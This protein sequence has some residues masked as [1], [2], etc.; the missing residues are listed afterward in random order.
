MRVGGDVG[1]DADG[2][3][4]PSCEDGSARAQQLQLARAFDIE[5]QDAGLQCRVDFGGQLADAGEHDVPDAPS[6]GGST[7]CSSPPETMSKP[8]PIPAS[9]RRIDKI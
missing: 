3:I 6:C 5:Q 4:A 9:I 7:R 1:I 8:A 2:E